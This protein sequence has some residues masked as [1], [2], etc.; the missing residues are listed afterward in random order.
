MTLNFL[1]RAGMEYRR[2]GKSGIKVSKFSLGTMAFGRWIDEKASEKCLLKKN[3]NL[4][5]RQITNL[6]TSEV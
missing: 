2:F 3:C 4:L 5:N 1:R 6:I